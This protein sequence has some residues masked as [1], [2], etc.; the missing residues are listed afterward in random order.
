MA[1]LY[2]WQ[3]AHEPNVPSLFLSSPQD[4]VCPLAD[5]RKFVAALSVRQPQRTLTGPVALSGAHC[6]R[7]VAWACSV[8]S[9]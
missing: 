6:Q 2:E 3:A 1:Q 5:V 7:I 4:V 9:H 8:W